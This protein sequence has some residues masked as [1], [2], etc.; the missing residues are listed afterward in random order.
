MDNISFNHEK[1]MDKI[2]VLFEDE[3]YENFH[4]LTYIR[5]V[6][7]LRS[8]I[9]TQMEKIT[10]S[11]PDYRPHLFC[12]PE[13]KELVAEQVDYPV[14]RI[15]A[16]ETSQLIFINGR[17]RISNDFVSALEKAGKNVILTSAGTVVAIKVTDGLRVDEI[18]DLNNG[19]LAEFVSK[20][21]KRSESLEMELPF[22][23]YLWHLV[24][25]IDAEIADDFEYCK[26]QTSNRIGE[27]Q[28]LLSDRQ[29]NDCFPG[30]HF[31]NPEKIY[32]AADAAILPGVV[33]DASAGPIFIDSGVRIEPHTYLIGPL[34]VG[35]NSMLVGGKISGS[36][37][38]PVCRVG[39]EV[40]ETIIQGYTNKYHAGFLG[41]A[42]VG[43]WVNL[44]AM[45]TNSDLKNNYST[46]KVLVNGND[47]DTENL[48]VGS[49]IGDFTKTAIGTLLNTGIN[50]GICCNIIPGGLAADKE[51]PNF[52]WYSSRSKL[53][54]KIA[55]ALDTIKRTMSRRGKELTPALE[56][57]LVELSQDK[58]EKRQ[59]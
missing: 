8:G 33:M 49:F 47:I 38:G 58:S 1:N 51:I 22:Y 10:G 4:P 14:N 59:E 32:I 24:K 34:Y 39:G 12:R 42:Y 48:K 17:L 3:K 54:Y 55:K 26:K 53:D 18:A 40:E 44:G 35:K 9:R 6:Y 19:D 36:S 37:I 21:R 28:K 31:I 30:S 56:K 20:I 13:L 16:S 50:I 43:E 46:V 29:K 2:I 57:R 7:F 11:F 45:T 5:P 41:H 25:A 27:L 23:E 52:C 15:M